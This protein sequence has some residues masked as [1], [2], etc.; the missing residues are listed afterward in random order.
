MNIFEVI[1][2]FEPK[3]RVIETRDFSEEELNFITNAVVVSGEYGPAVEFTRKDG[4]LSFIPLSQDSTL[5]PGD[6]VDLT[7]AKL[8]TLAKDGCENINRVDI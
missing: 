6:Y 8:L 4:K 5:L 1:K 3:W 7:K 2:S